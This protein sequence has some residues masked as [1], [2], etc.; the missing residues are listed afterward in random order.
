MERTD[1]LELMSTLK[2]YGMRAAG[3][4]PR[5]GFGP[6]RGDEVMTT[7]IKRRP[8]YK[9]IGRRASSAICSAPRLP[10]SRRARS[11]TN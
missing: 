2:L 9:P 10:R 11:S 7:A 6:T 8:V 4:C 5:A 1:I 3:A